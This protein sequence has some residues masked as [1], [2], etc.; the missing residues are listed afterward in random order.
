[1][2]MND[3]GAIP[4]HEAALPGRAAC[5]R[6]LE[7]D[8]SNS[9]AHA[10]LACFARVYDLDWM[11]AERHLAIALA[12]EAIPPYVHFL[13][14]V[15][16]YWLGRF[17]EAIREMESCIEKDPLAGMYRAVL[18]WILVSAGSM[19]RACVEVRRALE[20][21]PNFWMSH[22]VPFRSNIRGWLRC[23]PVLTDPAW[24]S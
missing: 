20:V 22:G 6:A 18:A 2:M 19:E 5:E 14:S 15:H 1:M 9:L 21:D 13:A 16:H 12:G 4:P 8:P 24:L 3:L 7:I 10:N 17:P 23:A 11:N